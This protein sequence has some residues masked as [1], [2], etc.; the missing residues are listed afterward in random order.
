MSIEVSQ[1]NYY[2]VKSCAG[3]SL[4]AAQID[5]RGIEHDREWAVLDA[6]S[7]AVLTQRQAAKMCLI[8]PSVKNS[9]ATFSLLLN[10]EDK[11]GIEVPVVDGEEV[12]TSF[13]WGPV[14]RGLDQGDAAA[15][16]LSS[17]LQRDCRLLHFS[18][19]YVR[20]VPQEF[21]KRATDQTGYADDFAW[22]LL[23]EESLQE[24]NSHMA[25][26]LPMNR[27][28]PNIVVRGTTAFGEDKWKMI[29]IG[30]VVFD[31]VKACGRCVIT[32]V[33]QADASKGVEPLKTLA[34]YRKVENS[35]LF[36]M[37]LAH[38]T[39]GSIAL[40]DEVEVLE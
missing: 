39:N 11:A 27:F 23:S 10:S 24:L 6:H 30:N 26:P 34:K 9:G 2:P 15:T 37:H 20:Q 12:E 40:H 25:E 8:K 16:W 33:N 31:V 35:L 4:D 17:Y 1:L 22:L 3:I 28:R 5:L 18:P 14:C 13:P 7:G 19:N 38:H 36:G 21:A 29:R 32:T